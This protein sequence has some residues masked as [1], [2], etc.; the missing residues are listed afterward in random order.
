MSACSTKGRNFMWLQTKPALALIAV[1]LSV[2]SPPLWAQGVGHYLAPRDQIVAIRAGHL[3]DSHNG[4]LFDN[5]VVLVHGER[6]A[7]VGSA[8][9]IPSGATNQHVR[10]VPK[11]GQGSVMPVWS[12]MDDL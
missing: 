9:Q 4:H 8:I 1:A 6:V 2:V 12:F 5:Q 7:E 11:S 3:F 10:F